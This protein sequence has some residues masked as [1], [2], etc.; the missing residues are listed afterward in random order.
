MNTLQKRIL[1]ILAILCAAGVAAYWYW[2]PYLAMRELRDAA[3]AADARRFNERVDFPKVRE[4]LKSQFSAR[5]HQ[6]ST[7]AG[8][9]FGSMLAGVLVDK[10]IDTAVRPETIMFAM[11]E[12]KFKIERDGGPEGRQDTGESHKTVWRT[13]RRGFN[14]ILFHGERE[15]ESDKKDTMALVMQRQGFADWKL[16]D[17]RLPD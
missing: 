12:G 9:N 10:L 7:D 2:S 6:D 5:M 3:V 16:T 17:I 15:G 8:T 4:S 1:S 14:T 13:E 11:R